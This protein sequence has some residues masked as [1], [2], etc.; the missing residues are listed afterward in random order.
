MTTHP[1]AFKTPDTEQAFANFDSLPYPKGASVIKQLDTLLGAENFRQGVRNYLKAQEFKNADYDDFMASLRNTR[2]GSLARWGDEWFKQ[3]G[4][5][6]VE[7]VVAC[8][9]GKISAFKILQQ[10]LTKTPPFRTNLTKLALYENRDDQLE[11]QCVIPVRYAR[12]QTDLPDL[13]GEHCPAFVFLNHDDND[14]VFELKDVEFSGSFAAS[15]APTLC[16]LASAWNLHRFI[17]E[18]P[19]LRP[20]VLKTLRIGEQEDRRCVK[21]REKASGPG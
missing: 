8:E 9:H 4:L 18:N 10:A 7:A 16:T 21:V 5:N 14:Y 17:A 19:G 13:V 1:V 3:A 20:V 12:Q 6:S 2:T 11:L 15:L